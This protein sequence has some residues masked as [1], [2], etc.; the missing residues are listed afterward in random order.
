M[1]IK[2]ILLFGFLFFPTLTFAHQPEQEMCPLQR[3]RMGLDHFNTI[4]FAATDLPGDLLLLKASEPIDTSKLSF[5]LAP[6]GLYV[7]YK[8]YFHVDYVRRL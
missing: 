7:L 2:R 1:N 5:A 6:Y 4:S 8:E 3:A